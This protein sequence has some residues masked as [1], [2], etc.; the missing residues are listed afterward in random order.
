MIPALKVLITASMP[1]FELRGAIPLAIYLGLPPLLA[2]IISVLGN[3]L[4]IPFLLIF[5][6]KIRSTAK[7][8]EFTSGVLELFE[9]RALKNKEIIDKYGYFGLT[10]FVAIPLPVT[11]AWTG[12]LLSSLLYLEPKK[13]LIYIALGVAIAGLVVLSSTLGFL[14]LKDVFLP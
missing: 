9:K 8:Y 5:L 13:A 1:I 7:K 6:D 2:Y 10:L 4:P 12:C 3:L 14:S 11:G